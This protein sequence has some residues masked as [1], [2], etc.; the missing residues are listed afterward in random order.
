MIEKRERTDREGRSYTV[1]RVRAAGVDRTLPRGTTRKQ[2]QQ[3][4]TTVKQAAQTGELDQL[5]AG[6][7]TLADFVA[8]WWTTYADANLAH[9]TLVNYK[10]MWE[11]HL[12]NRVGGY[13]LRELRPQ[14]IAQLASDLERDGVGRPTIRK[15]LGL[16]QGVLARAVEWGRIPSNP[17]KGIRK[18]T[19]VRQH[20]VRVLTPREV[21]ALRAE[22]DHRDATIVSCLVYRQPKTQR[23]PRTVRLITPLAR[24]LAS[25]QLACGRPS[26][27][28][29]FPDTA[30]T[31]WNRDQ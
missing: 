29:V 6:M 14:V 24:D 7:E 11:R 8:E 18:P 31:A 10:I 22:M 2:A 17:V 28:P 26:A 13:R 30:D 15:T 12:V 5:D 3:W 16:L 20:V 4:E 9:A 27:G 1:Y 19:V 21:E 23:A 25:W